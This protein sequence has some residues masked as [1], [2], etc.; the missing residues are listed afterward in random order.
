[1]TAAS[2]V[3]GWVVV[4]CLIYLVAVYGAYLGM[5]V[6]SAVEAQSRRSRR[7]LENLE[8]MRES[9]LTIPVS[10][11]APV[12]NEEPIVLAA[13]RS[14][15]AVDYPAHEV[16]VV[17]DG[18]T[19][20]TL[21][22]LV[23]EF[24]LRPVELVYRR[25]FATKPVRAVYRSRTEPRLVVVDKENGGK[26][27]SLNS[28]L[29]LARYRYV[30]GVDGDTILTRR[31][32]LD[33]MRLV[34][35]DP[36]RVIGVTG[37]IT[38]SSTPEESLDQDGAP[39]RVE[40]R[41]MLAF[42]H[43]DFLRSFFNNRLGWTR[44]NTMLCAVGAFQIWRLDVLEELGGFSTTFTCEDIELTFRVHE[45]MRREG[46]PY[47]LLSLPDTVGVTE[48]PDRVRTLIAQRERWQ[49][50]ILET[51]IHYRRMM[52]R[53]RYGS[54]G[55]VGVPFFVLSEVL[56][57][58]FE[59]VAL[60]TLAVGVALGLLDIGRALLLLALLALINGLFT[61]AAVMLEDRTSR[62]YPVS[63]LALLI[64]LGLVDMVAYRP[65]IFWAR[66]KGSW[67]YLRGD[68]GWHKFERNLRSGAAA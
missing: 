35:A 41:P 38:V 17:N 59:V 63:D 7:R 43:L 14:F 37:H 12:H 16:I 33:G 67:R 1:M 36:R 40:H 54:V 56:A 4:A 13:T 46:R 48:A 24:D 60:V 39:H 21:A 51:V 47:R 11:V 18:S 66:A 65:L 50:V 10:I 34:L 5:L 57:P 22:A 20:G 28:G 3:L 25:R 55:F 29:N 32:L 19:D 23:R 31:S 42:Q 62:A 26:A 6:Y 27:D 45:K 52:F 53:R 64:A 30:C 8:R 15:L 2:A 68:K 9:P 49:R 61:S 58:L 44:L